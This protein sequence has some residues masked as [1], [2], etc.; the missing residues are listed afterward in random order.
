MGLFLRNILYFNW[1]PLVQSIIQK[2]NHDARLGSYL[3]IN[4]V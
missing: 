3:F 4:K 2:V 1:K